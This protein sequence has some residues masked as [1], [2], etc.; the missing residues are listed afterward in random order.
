LR[1]EGAVAGAVALEGGAGS[2]GL[3]A[4]ELDDEAVAWPSEVGLGL[5]VW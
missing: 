4:V 5:L 2:V 1:L 3:V